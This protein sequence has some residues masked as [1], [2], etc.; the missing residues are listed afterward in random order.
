MGNLESFDIK[1]HVVE[2]MIE[3]FDTKEFAREL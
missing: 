2:S 3:V 1:S